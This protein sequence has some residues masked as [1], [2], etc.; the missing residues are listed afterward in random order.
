MLTVTPRVAPTL[1]AKKKLFTL[2]L[3]KKKHNLVTSSGL[4]KIRLTSNVHFIQV[5]LPVQIYALIVFYLFSLN[6]ER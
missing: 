5:H 2:L 6:L 3:A 1:L 4:D